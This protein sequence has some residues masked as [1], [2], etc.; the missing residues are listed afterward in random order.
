MLFLKGGRKVDLEGKYHPSARPMGNGRLR[1]R[2]QLCKCTKRLKRRE[3]EA[4][5]IGSSA[6]LPEQIC[7]PPHSGTT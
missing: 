6:P 1:A 5:P 7:L 4:D 2:K 3:E